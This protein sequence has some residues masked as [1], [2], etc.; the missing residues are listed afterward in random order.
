M[1]IPVL[2]SLEREEKKHFSLSFLLTMFSIIDIDHW[3]TRGQ[4]T[5]LTSGLLLISPVHCPHGTHPPKQ[6]VNIQPGEDEVLYAC[7]I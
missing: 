1:H 7:G 6:V 5:V 3:T 2:N 4:H